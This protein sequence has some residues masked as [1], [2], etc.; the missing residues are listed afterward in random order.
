MSLLLYNASADCS[1]WRISDHVPVHF[2]EA[3]FGDADVKRRD[4]SLMS[5]LDESS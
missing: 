3:V 4:E 1:T 2:E 5:V